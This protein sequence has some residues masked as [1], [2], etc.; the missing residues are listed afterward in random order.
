MTIR[1]QKGFRSHPLSASG[2]LGGARETSRKI[3]AGM[4]TLGAR[5]AGGG[6][7]YGT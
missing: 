4:Q 2:L 6:G 1:V 5:G 3:K 7:V